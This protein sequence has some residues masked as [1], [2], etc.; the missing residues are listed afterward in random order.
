ME[1]SVFDV[2]TPHDSVISISRYGNVKL[3]FEEK[4]IDS[5][6][7]NKDTND[8]KVKF[9]DEM[10]L[11]ETNFTKD[12]KA[13]LAEVLDTIPA[14]NTFDFASFTTFSKKYRTYC[15]TF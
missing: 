6:D 12:R 7:T 11:V 5:E 3:L 14:G 1:P 2:A 13:S 8:K 10:I 4:S 15:W 9:E